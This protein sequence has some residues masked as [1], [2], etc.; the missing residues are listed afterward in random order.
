MFRHWHAFLTA[1]L[2]A[3]CLAAIVACRREVASGSASQPTSAAGFATPRD[4]AQALLAALRDL[5]HA[6][7]RGDRRA[8]V[9]HRDYVIRSLLARNDILARYQAIAGRYPR[10]QAEVLPALVDNWAAIIAPYADALD[11]E[12]AQVAA[13]A[14]RTGGAVVDV[15]AA[16]PSGATLVRVACL[17]GEDDCWRVAVLELAPAGAPTPGTP[18][19]ATTRSAS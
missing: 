4:A 14:E 1:G 8:S 15:P 6:S 7:A 12:R 19:R 3:A 13:L 18:E 2:L 16:G 10:S 5:L 11:L 9:E 17:R